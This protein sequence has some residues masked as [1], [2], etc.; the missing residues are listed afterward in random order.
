MAPLRRA[1]YSVSMKKTSQRIAAV[2][3]LVSA[4]YIRLSAG[5]GDS[6]GVAR[7][8]QM[9]AYTGDQVAGAFGPEIVDV[10]GMDMPTGPI[11]ILLSHDRD[12]RVGYSESVDVDGGQINIQGRMLTADH[13]ITQDADEGFPFQSSIGFRVLEV[14]RVEEGDARDVNG[15]EFSG[16]GTVITKSRLLESSFVP[17]G[18]DGATSATVYALGDEF[19]EEVAMADDA[20]TDETVE[21]APAVYSAAT[22]D[23]LQGQ[24]PGEAEF[25][26]TAFAAQMTVKQAQASKAYSDSLRERLVAEQRAHEATRRQLGAEQGVEFSASETR[27][28]GAAIATAEP[29]NFEQRT[30][31]DWDVDADTRAEFRTFKDF[32]A[33]ERARAAG[34]CRIVTGVIGGTA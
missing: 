6:P 32:Q 15:R 31:R 29:M 30:K 20:R 8:F 2:R 26:L 24:F 22:I 23:E 25:V 16:P 12:K 7:R 19:L 14:D 33:Y 10:A 4:D 3:R 27:E 1:F 11:P 13:G 17:L 18:A 9:S 28:E 34:R 5:D 21:S